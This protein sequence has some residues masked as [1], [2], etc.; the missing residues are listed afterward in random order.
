MIEGL[1]INNGK[2]LTK[3][4]VPGTKVYQERLIKIK[5]IEYREW[6]P[7][8]SKLA[9]AIKKK[10]SQLGIK[11]DSIILY[12][13]CSTGTTVSHLSDL[14]TEGFIFAL[15]SA[16]RVLRELILMA[17]D[18]NNIAPILADAFQTETFEDKVS[19]VDVIYQDIAQRNQA[20]IFI[21]NCKK[22]LKKEGFA[23]LCLKSRSADVKKTPRQ[24]YK[25]VRTQLEKELRVVD[26]R[27][28]DPF[29]KHHGFFVCKNI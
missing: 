8:H 26:F 7:K 3:N 23:I 28:L 4:Q 21:E 11:K 17:E 14:L 5:G 1:L 20:E 27:E 15:D 9:S 24:V 16:P 29:Q 22:F 19:K 2:L 12:L 18:R 13:G 6:I 25:E 10:I